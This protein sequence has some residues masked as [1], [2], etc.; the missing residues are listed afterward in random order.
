MRSTYAATVGGAYFFGIVLNYVCQGIFTLRGVR[1]ILRT[2]LRFAVVAL[3]S[4]LLTMGS[5]TSILSVLLQWRWLE[6]YA[7]DIAFACGALMV[8]PLSFHLT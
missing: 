6:D 7:P 8:S 5:S 1:G 4:A 2:F 3:C